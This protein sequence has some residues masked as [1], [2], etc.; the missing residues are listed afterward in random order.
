MS[1]FILVA[2]IIAAVLIEC[3]IYERHWD[4]GVTARIG[5]GVDRTVEGGASELVE[6]V[7][8]GGRMRLPWLSVK[9]QASKYL[10]LPQ[11]DN[12]NVTDNY[13][14]EDVFC[15]RPGERI[16][17]RLPIVCEKRGIHSIGAID[18]ISR[19]MFMVERLVTNLPGHATITVFPKQVDVSDI[20]FDARR[21]MGDFITKK[22]TIEDPFVF[23]GLRDYVEGDDPR[24]IN[25]RASAKTDRMTVN[26][27]ESTTSLCASIW[28][29]C[30]NGTGW[31]D[32][33]VSEESIR[34]A[35]SLAASL[36]DSGVPVSF[37][38]NGR[39]FYTQAEVKHIPGG[40]SQQHLD[41]IN[42]AL[43][44]IELGLK[45]RRMDSAAEDMLA[46]SATEDFIVIIS[47]DLDPRLIARASS[48]RESGR[49][50]LWI[51]PVRRDDTRDMDELSAIPNHYVWRAKL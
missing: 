50:V 37:C 18:L 25:W 48:L 10:S 26:Q 16:T 40:C 7:E 4:D 9:F 5:F 27:Y 17:R 47:A 39:D 28:L 2:A 33:I 23:R 34:I 3:R 32:E 44:R 35:S 1:I 30:E 20:V 49:E 51:A 12:A 36:I 8:H 21:T 38:T 42:T 29:N 19:D 15:I 6:V 11:E 14:R 46:L 13:Y 31:F 22:R 45:P 43:A 24:S 41:N